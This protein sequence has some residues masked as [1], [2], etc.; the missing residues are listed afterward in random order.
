MGMGGAGNVSKSGNGIA[1]MK[2]APMVASSAS[3]ERIR[4]SMFVN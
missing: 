4:P 3:R 2:K 1:V